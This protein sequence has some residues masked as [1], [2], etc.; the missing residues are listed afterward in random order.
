MW[1]SGVPVFKWM[2]AQTAA[3]DPT[4]ATKA[5]AETIILSLHPPAQVLDSFTNLAANNTSAVCAPTSVAEQWSCN[6]FSA[7][8]TLTIPATVHPDGSVTYP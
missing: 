2:N 7:D 5:G 3:A 4:P 8:R 6:V 1:A